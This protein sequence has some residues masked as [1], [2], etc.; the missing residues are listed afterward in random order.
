MESS[1]ERPLPRH[2]GMYILPNLFTTASL[3]AAFLGILYS[4]GEQ[5]MLYALA[6]FHAEL[7]HYSLNSVSSEKSDKIIFQS[8]VETALSRVALSSGASSELIVYAARLM[9]FCAYYA[10]S[11]CRYDLV[12]LFGAYSLILGK[13]FFIGCRVGFGVYSPSE[14]L[15]FCQEFGISSEDYVSSSSSHVCCY[16]DGSEASCLSYYRCFFVVNLGI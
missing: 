3:F 16:S 6:L 8:Y 10:K 9:A 5:R 11:A 14:H 4:F 15:F 1:Q 7:F 13:H 12:M 2:K